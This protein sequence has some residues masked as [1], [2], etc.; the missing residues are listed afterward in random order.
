MSRSGPLYNLQG[1]TQLLKDELINVQSIN[2][3]INQ[4]NNLGYFSFYK[5]SHFESTCIT[6]CIQIAQSLNSPSFLWVGLLTTVFLIDKSS[7]KSQGWPIVSMWRIRET[8]KVKTHR[9][10]ILR[11]KKCLQKSPTYSLERQSMQL[12]VSPD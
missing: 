12:L 11:Y 2:P 5:L 10:V 7:K 8:G 1:Y 9:R 6:K 4:S 3:S